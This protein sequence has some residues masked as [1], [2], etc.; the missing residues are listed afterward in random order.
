MMMSV[1][2]LSAIW[3]AVVSL[4]SLQLQRASSTQQEVGGPGAGLNR[5]NKSLAPAG[6]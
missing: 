4:M 3:T 1:L 2:N 5:R 6:I